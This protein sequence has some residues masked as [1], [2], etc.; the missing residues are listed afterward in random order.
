ML[1][2][3]KCALATFVALR[4]FHARNTLA[5]LNES[6]VDK[7]VEVSC[8][9]NGDCGD[10]Q[11]CA[12]S[13]ARPYAELIC[14]SAGD[15]SQGASSTVRV[16]RFPDWDP[17]QMECFVVCKNRAAGSACEGENSVCASG[18]CG[19]DDRCTDEKFVDESPCRDD[20]QCESGVC[21]KS[22]SVVGAE[23]VCCS[24]GDAGFD[25]SHGTV[26]AERPA[27]AA[28]SGNNDLCA[29]GV[30]GLDDLCKDEVP[31][32]CI[33]VPADCGE[34]HVTRFGTLFNGTCNS[35]QD[36]WHCE[37][38][39]GCQCGDG[40]GENS[41]VCIGAPVACEEHFNVA[42]C[43]SQGGCTWVAYNPGVCVDAACGP[44]YRPAGCRTIVCDHVET[45]C[46]AAQSRTECLALGEE[47]LGCD[48]MMLWRDWEDDSVTASSGKKEEQDSNKTTSAVPPGTA[49]A[50]DNTHLS[51]PGSMYLPLKEIFMLGIS[52]TAFLVDM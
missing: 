35:P 38:R 19:M 47:G 16:C 1:S 11:Q 26:C 15:T 40:S 3:S 7:P 44:L 22:E 5:E 27:G 45:P 41:K 20:D 2:Y 32:V 23:L 29:S 14:C 24:N 30:C 18:V 28:C 48:W 25:S 9:T 43:R 42:S 17:V 37:N 34:V 10:S 52:L 39:S 49:P 36:T 13:E 50:A 12:R 4:F 51:S 21:A 46:R 8:T 31:G 33:G 6:S